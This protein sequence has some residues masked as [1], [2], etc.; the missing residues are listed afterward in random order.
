MI[1]SE[2]PGPRP[3]TSPHTNL[4]TLITLIPPPSAACSKGFRNA[5]ERAVPTL[6]LAAPTPDW[7][8][9]ILDWTVSTIDWAAL[10]FDWAADRARLLRHSTW[11]LFRCSTAHGP[12]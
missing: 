9:S 10:T 11:L 4:I 1:A 5:L 2:M 7:A 6:D 12:F 8:F 3:Q